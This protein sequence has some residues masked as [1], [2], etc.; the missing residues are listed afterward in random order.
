[1]VRPLRIEY[2]GAWYHV[3]NRG[4]EKRKI[5]CCD[6]DY[7]SFFYLLGEIS[8]IY[9]VEL[10]A[11]SLMPNHY[12]LLVH[13]PKAGLSLPMKYL[14]GLYTQIF[15]KAHHRDGPLLRGR[16]KAI[17]V[18]SNE[19]LMGL[20]CYIHNNPVKAQLCERPEDHRW[21]S[22]RYYLRSC[23]GFEWLRTQSV[24]GECGHHSGRSRKKFDQV[25]KSKQAKEIVTEIE[26]HKYSIIGSPHFK[27]WVSANYVEQTKKEDPEFAKTETSV[28]PAIKA[29]EILSNVGFC[30]NVDVGKIRQGGSGKKNE[31]RTLAIYLL[32]QH[33]GYG[34]S[35][36]AKW[37]RIKNQN[38]VAQSLYKFKQRM[39]KDKM[40]AK[41]VRELERAILK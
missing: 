28:K 35:K 8:K 2:D 34:L 19:Y 33:K 18:D 21:T 29:Q 13:T 17:V 9:A 30:Y 7:F 14:N 36:I 38:A 31:A 16:Y 22:H 37:L 4:L 26:R 23:K 39:A 25:V 5:F 12:H 41:K 6:K 40:F 10:H 11:F 27:K 3:I 15:N 1:M 32:R 24:L 20:V